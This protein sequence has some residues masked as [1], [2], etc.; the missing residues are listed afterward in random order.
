[1]FRR[2]LG[3]EDSTRQA[4][5]TKVALSSLDPEQFVYILIRVSKE[6]EKYTLNTFSIYDESNKIFC[7]L[8]HK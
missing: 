3:K 1:M 4:R 5:N 6:P 7:K 2:L 8:C